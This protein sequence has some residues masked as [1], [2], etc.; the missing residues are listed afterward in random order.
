M[1]G[2]KRHFDDETC[3]KKIPQFWQEKPKDV[4]GRLGVCLPCHDGLDYLIGDFVTNNQNQ[5]LEI[6]SL[7]AKTCAI[8]KGHGPL[9]IALQKLNKEIY[10]SW[11]I[12]SGYQDDEA[13]CLEYYDDPMKYPQGTKDPD[14]YLN[15]GLV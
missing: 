4:M 2:I 8:F 15:C 11:F 7:P 6:V 5:N 14:Y 10:S 1:I 13:Y 9:P 3:L 12:N